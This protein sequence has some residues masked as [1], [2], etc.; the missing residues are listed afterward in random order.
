MCLASYIFSFQLI[1]QN[2][3]RVQLDFSKK[4]KYFG[5][6]NTQFKP[7]LAWNKNTGLTYATSLKQD[8]QFVEP[9]EDKCFNAER[10]TK[11]SVGIS[12]YFRNGVM[13]FVET[14]C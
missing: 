11:L 2:E 10:I 14:C 7:R 3:V 6:I 4:C 8:Y 9:M 5:I 13:S 12:I 1:L